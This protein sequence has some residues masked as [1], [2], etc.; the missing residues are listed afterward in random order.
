VAEQRSLNLIGG[1]EGNPKNLC[2]DNRTSGQYSKRAP[3]LS[4]CKN[5]SGLK[6]KLGIICWV[7]EWVS[8]CE[9]VCV[10]VCV[11]VSEREREREREMPRSCLNSYRGMI[12]API[13]L[14]LPTFLGMSGK[15]GAWGFV[16][17]RNASGHN[18]NGNERDRLQ[19]TCAPLHI[20][21]NPTCVII[22]AARWRGQKFA[23]IVT[24][25]LFREHFYVWPQSC[26]SP[27]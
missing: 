24:F 4:L 18:A 11:C 1:T 22:T 23:C 2:Q 27:Y 14:A 9:C 20:Q 6:F 19:P 10:C 3:L 25:K 5:T 15:H 12:I 21:T 8:E 26:G 16:P 13:R 7:Q 17:P